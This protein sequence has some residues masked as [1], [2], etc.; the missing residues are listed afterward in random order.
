MVQVTMPKSCIKNKIIFFSSSWD[1]FN[2]S[3]NGWTNGQTDGRTR[4]LQY[5]PFSTSGDIII[6][7]YV[8]QKR[9]RQGRDRMVFGFTTTQSVP[10][11]WLKLWVRIPLRWGVLDTALCDKICQ[12]LSTGRWFSPGTM[13]SS[14]NKTDRHDI[15]DI[16]SNLS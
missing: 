12:W 16:Q 7:K 4:W 8:P 2:E 14:T 6:S 11:T 15:T 9:G 5:S 1:I 3:V 10:I 13:F